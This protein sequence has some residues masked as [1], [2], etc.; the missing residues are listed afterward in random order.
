MFE[1]KG[2]IIIDN[3]LYFGAM[4]AVNGNFR[5]TKT[6][7]GIASESLETLLGKKR[8]GKKMKGKFTRSL[9][10]LEV[11]LHSLDLC[12]CNCMRS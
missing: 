9:L 3:T 12:N 6:I 11:Q 1:H 10:L 8:R 4:L 7:S 2:C 5:K